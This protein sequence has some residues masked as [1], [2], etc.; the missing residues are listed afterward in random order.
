[1]KLTAAQISKICN[2]FCKENT[3]VDVGD[4]ILTLEDS[5]VET[6]RGDVTRTA[7]LKD[8]EGNLYSCFQT[9]SY[10]DGNRSEYITSD[11]SDQYTEI[12]NGDVY[13][14]EWDLEIELAEVEK[15][16][17]VKIVYEVK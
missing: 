1:M 15:R 8:S 2:S 10:D 11:S 16:E 17:I 6:E 3:I 13:S 9:I 14:G 7:I 12:Y 5:V 4:N